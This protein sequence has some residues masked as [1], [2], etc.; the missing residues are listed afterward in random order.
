MLIIF[1]ENMIFY[2]FIYLSFLSRKGDE[3]KKSI[4]NKV[5]FTTIKEKPLE[6]LTLV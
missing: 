4:D 1:A 2:L 6:L 3:L 5:L